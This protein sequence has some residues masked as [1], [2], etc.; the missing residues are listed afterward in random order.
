MSY[1]YLQMY[2]LNRKMGFEPLVRVRVVKQSAYKSFDLLGEYGTVDNVSGTIRVVLDDVKNP[3]SS[4]G[5]FY[6]KPSEL[7]II[8]ENT[9][10]KTMQNNITNYLNIAKIKF[11]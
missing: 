3:N 4:Y 8:N 11:M 9:E 7:A 5:A 2:A 10:E 6:F 1:D